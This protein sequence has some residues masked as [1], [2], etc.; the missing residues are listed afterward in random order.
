MLDPT[1]SRNPKFKHLVVTL[2]SRHWNSELFM[3]LFST[4]DLVTEDWTRFGSMQCSVRQSLPFGSL[5]HI[6][7]SSHKTF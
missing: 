2:F 7:G 1:R 6:K 5:C 4:G 3:L